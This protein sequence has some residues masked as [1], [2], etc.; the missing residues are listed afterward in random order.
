VAINIWTGEI[1]SNIDFRREVYP[2]F[3]YDATYP[4]NAILVNDSI[5]AYLSYEGKQL[6]FSLLKDNKIFLSD[7]KELESGAIY[8]N[9]KEDF[10]FLVM[11]GDNTFSL[12]DLSRKAN[13][14][15]GELPY[16]STS[17]V[18]YESGDS[19]IYLQHGNLYCI[20]KNTGKVRFQSEEVFK[21]I[22]GYCAK[23]DFKN[24]ISGD[25]IMAIDYSSIG[26]FDRYS[27]KL[28]NFVK[29]DNEDINIED[30]T[31]FNEELVMVTSDPV[32][33]LRMPIDDLLK[34]KNLILSTEGFWPKEG[35]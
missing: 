24:W 9:P 11:R 8:N 6:S 25:R 34:K 23:M 4:K 19:L 10:P 16:T 33:L 7:T 31:I 22:G 3:S 21:F 18:S 12:Y 13:W 5:T 17:T 35:N 29:F 30:A 20:N 1:L 28:R 32:M 14:T 15:V 26:V 2:T 27:G